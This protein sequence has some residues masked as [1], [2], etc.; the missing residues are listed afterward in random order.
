MPV[1]KEI[2]DILSELSLPAGAIGLAMGLVRGA[3]ALEKDASEPALKYISDLLKGGGLTSF[4]KIGA[5]LV[6]AIFDRVFGQNH[7]ALSLFLDL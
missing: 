5:T 1:P 3:G 2:T 4:G 7:S 6:P